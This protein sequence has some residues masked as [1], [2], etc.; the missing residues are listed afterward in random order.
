MGIPPLSWQTRRWLEEA[1]KA[2]STNA[3]TTDG[4]DKGSA[5]REDVFPYT[6]LCLLWLLHTVYYFQ[7][8]QRRRKSSTVCYRDI[9]VRRRY[10]KLWITIFSTFR[11]EELPPQQATSFDRLTDD[12]SSL[13]LPM[14]NSIENPAQHSLVSY[15]HLRTIARTCSRFYTFIGGKAALRLFYFSHLIWSCRA[16]ETYFGSSVSYLSKILSC[17]VLHICLVIWVCHNSLQF[18]P[19]PRHRILTRE[20]PIS[21]MLLCI[22]PMML[23]HAAFPHAVIPAIPFFYYPNSSSIG[24]YIVLLLPLGFLST[25]LTACRMALSCYIWV[26]IGMP[27]FELFALLSFVLMSHHWLDEVGW[28]R[29]TGSLLIYDKETREWSDYEPYM[30]TEVIES[31]R[32]SETDSDSDGFDEN[33]IAIGSSDDDVE[34]RDLSSA[35]DERIPLTENGTIWRNEMRSRRGASQNA[36]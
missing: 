32:A 10:H 11:T 4:F 17:V 12:V 35:D 36:D 31:P 23:F 3:D 28:D 14:G 7:R 30:N 5:S 24:G 15:H 21:P 25:L 33:S 6:T 26:R 22:I 13:T 20:L 1:S 19:V 34:Q 2:S 9:V 8:K 18:L 16:L 29:R 27:N